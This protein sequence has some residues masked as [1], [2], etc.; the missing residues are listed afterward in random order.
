MIAKFRAWVEEDPDALYRR[1]ST[2]CIV[3]TLSALAMMT[4]GASK[5]L[6]LVPVA[7]VGICAVLIH[8]SGSARERAQEDE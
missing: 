1:S 7:I 2:L 5:G 3:S 4:M 6:T 8:Q